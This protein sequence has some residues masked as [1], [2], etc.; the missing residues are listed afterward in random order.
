M[1]TI[2]LSRLFYFIYLLWNY[3]SRKSR[4]GG[5]KINQPLSVSLEL[6]S[7]CN[8]QC[9]E[10]P[11]GQ[12][13]VKRE[14]AFMSVEIAKKIIDRHAK[15]AFI[16]QLFFQGE[17]FLNQ[18][19]SKILEYAHSKKLYT[20]ISTNGHFLTA[21][22]CK[23]LIDSKLNRIIISIDG[24]TAEVYRQ[25]RRNGRFE[26][27]KEGIKRLSTMRNMQKAK[28]PEIVLQTLLTRE[29]EKQIYN[30]KELKKELGADS[31]NFKTMQLYDLSDKNREYWLPQKKRF[32]RYSSQ[33]KRKAVNC[34]RALSTAVYT[35]DGDL[36]ACCFDKS[37]EFN[38]G[39]IDHNPWEAD[40]H[41]TFLQNLAVGKFVPEICYNCV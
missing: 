6:A 20:I 31:V 3:V 41:K 2:T 4:K 37:A 8:L 40:K 11:A 22:N 29:T 1:R 38:F 39:F 36:V 35:T 32:S 17:P 5:K 7:V 33:K 30:F 24:T 21:K 15:S 10:C 27:V 9:V 16:A 18:Q 26:L 12:G 28:Y 13:K 34:W 19:W 14:N 23:K 25:Y